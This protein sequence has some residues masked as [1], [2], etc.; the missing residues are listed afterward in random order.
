MTPRADRFEAR[1]LVVLFLVALQSY[2]L[3]IGGEGVSANYL[4]IFIPA[5]LWIAG[6]PRRLRLDRDVVLLLLIF[7]AI[8]LLG[9][10]F[11]L[12]HLGEGI[13]GP[14]R[15]L[16]SFL[17]FVFPFTLALFEFRP[18]DM[19]PFKVALLLASLY[20]SLLSIRDVAPL[21]ETIS[22]PEMKSR[23]GS[24]RYGFILSMGLFVALLDPA[25]LWKRALVLQRLVFSL[26]II[27]GL[28]LTFSRSSIVSVGV[29]ALVAFVSVF[30]QRAATATPGR[31]RRRVSLPLRVVSA[32]AMVAVLVWGTNTLLARFNLDL[33]GFY[34]ERLVTPLADQTLVE[35]LGEAESSE[36]FRLHLVQLVVEYLTVHPFIGSSYQGL[37]LMFEEFRA[38]GS[39]H[40]QYL[41]V[42]ARTGLV[43]GSLW[44]LALWRI[45]RFTRFDP[46][47]RAGLIAVI[48]YGAFHETFKESQGSVV[49][50]VLFS[51]SYLP[52]SAFSGTRESATPR[53]AV[54]QKRTPTLVPSAM[55]SPTPNSR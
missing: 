54:S 5:V 12:S 19:R 24:A 55:A 13:N 28:L 27:A 42:F 16:A 37:Y 44:V 2:S 46:A 17:V 3:R 8:Y 23:V 51:L 33:W 48:V 7:S 39:F 20:Y 38:G 45:F 26:I 21:I 40:N 43:G 53:A 9:L 11:D 49:F 35:R 32:V 25:L 15:R 30:R 52:A 18:S 36:G 22:V 14:L 34:Q 31:S 50:A 10:P 29:A 6:R 4:Y 1:L 47:L 41:D